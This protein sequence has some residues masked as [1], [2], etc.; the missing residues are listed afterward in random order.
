MNNLFKLSINIFILVVLFIGLAHPI[1]AQTNISPQNEV[2]DCGILAGEGSFFFI[3][4]HFEST[5]ARHGFEK[6]GCATNSVHQW[7]GI[8]VQDFSG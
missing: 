2:Q 8:I 7:N 6:M 4:T 1:F 3:Q 5:Y